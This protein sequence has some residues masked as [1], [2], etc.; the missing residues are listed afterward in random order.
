MSTRYLDKMFKPQSVAVIG[1]GENL[2]SVGYVVLSNLKKGGFGGWIMPVNPNREMVL[3][4]K[5]FSDVASL[6]VV[7]DLAIV[8]VQAGIVPKIIDELAAA[9]TRAAV[10]ITAGAGDRLHGYGKLWREELMASSGICNL[11]VIG[12]NCLGVMVPGHCLNGSFSHLQPLTGS[13]AFVA[14]SGAVL[15]TV[16]EWATERDIGFTHLVSL[17]DMADVDFGDMLNYLAAD[18]PTRAILL[19]IESITEAPKFMAAAMAAARKKPVV[20]VKAGRYDRSG[21]AAFSHSGALFGDDD[22]YDAA[23]RRAGMLRVM[24]LE[25]LFAS[26]ETLAVGQRFHGERLAMVSNGGGIGVMATDTLMDKCGRPA[27]LSAAT[28]EQLNRLLPPTWSGMNPV[29]IG[30]DADDERY[31]EVLSVLLEDDGID[32]V[33]AMHSPSAVASAV[34]TAQAV[35][36]TVNMAQG[37]AGRKTVLAS[38]M[39]EKSSEA[40]RRLF[41]RSG[42]PCYGTPTDG[43]RGFMQMVRYHRSQ[44][45][46]QGMGADTGLVPAT[47]RQLARSSIASALAAGREWLEAQEIAELLRSCGIG[48]DDAVG[49]PFLPRPVIAMAEDDLFGPVLL[50]GFQN[51]DDSRL[52]DRIAALPPL[53]IALAMETVGR[54]RTEYLAGIPA[55]QRVLARLGQLLVSVSELICDI[56]EIKKLRLPLVLSEQ[57][58]VT[59]FGGIVR[60]GAALGDPAGRLAIR[61]WRDCREGTDNQEG[62]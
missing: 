51:G 15:S 55:Q 3:G 60:I 5:C 4:C 30:G 27:T 10:V 58:E 37:N 8:A 38:W 52:H 43:V 54:I 36:R 28:V 6:P 49:A 59:V 33:L 41:R 45:T 35:I 31:A 42:I 56:A 12:P 11:R 57:G 16:L 17:G 20:V 46:L 32:G 47:D 48:V 39:G 40:A 19:Y 14:Q 13:I 34:E 29:D 9:G 7:P 26:V 24:D 2:K 18:P 23:F 1:A 44:K 53:N 25:A 61:P 22:V 62:R 50:L 21:A